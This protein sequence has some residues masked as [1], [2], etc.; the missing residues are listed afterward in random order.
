MKCKLC[1]CNLDKEV[2]DDELDFHISA[3]HRNDFCSNCWYKTIYGN[4][5]KMTDNT[6]MKNINK[7]RT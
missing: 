6:E 5:N 2:E 4:A 7:I 1:G 3:A